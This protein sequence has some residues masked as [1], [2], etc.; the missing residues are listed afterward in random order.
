MSEIITDYKELHTGDVICYDGMKLIVVGL[1]SSAYYN[2]D[3]LGAARADKAKIL[4]GVCNIGIRWDIH[5]SVEKLGHISFSE[6]IDNT[7]K[8]Y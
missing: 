7:L 5:T 8:K 3:C 6:F 4:N 2:V 1:S